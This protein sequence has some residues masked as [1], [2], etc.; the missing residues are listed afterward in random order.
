MDTSTLQ[1]EPMEDKIVKRSRRKRREIWFNP[2]YS[3]HVKSNV[4]KEFL[5]LVDS[6]FPPSNP[7]H[8]I[9]NRHTLKLS[10][11]CMPNMAQTVARQNKAKLSDGQDLQPPPPCSCDTPCPVGGQCKRKDVVYQATVTERSS[12]NFQTYTGLT[13]RTFLTRYKEHLR[14]FE[15]PSKRTSSKLAGH[16]WDLKDNGVEFDVSWGL[17]AKAPPFNPITRKCLLCLKEKHFIMYG[18]G[19]STLNKRSEIF[20]TCRHRL[21]DLLVKVKC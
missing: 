14:D 8:K 9:F 2:P 21:R 12:Q 16:I 3:I 10:Y 13:Y 11:R 18:E 7:L 5:K 1:Y 15:D 17:L 19:T 20:N 4:G 6:A